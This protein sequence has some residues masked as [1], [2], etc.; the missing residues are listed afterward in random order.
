MFLELRCGSGYSFDIARDACVNIRECEFGVCEK[1]A[2]C[3]DT[4]GSFKCA[5][6]PG[7]TLNSDGLSCA[8]IHIL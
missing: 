4:D 7:F 8:G 5:C 3:I 1:G 2:E 6:P